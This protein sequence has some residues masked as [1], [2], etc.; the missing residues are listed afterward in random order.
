MVVEAKP[1]KHIQ[2]EILSA[3]EE[4]EDL[5]KRLQLVAMM[6]ELER[7]YPEDMDREAV[8]DGEVCP[9][10]AWEVASDLGNAKIMLEEA[11][12]SLQIASQHTADSI[13]TAWLRSRLESVSDPAIQSLLGFLLSAK[14]DD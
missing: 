8:G 7:N 1:V 9:P 4:L 6:T 10:L 11:L 13:R 12:Q 5:V 3:A 14:T 2:A